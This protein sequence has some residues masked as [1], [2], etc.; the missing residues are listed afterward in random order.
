MQVRANK[1]ACF[2]PERR[3]GHAAALVDGLLASGASGHDMLAGSLIEAVAALVAEPEC[4]TTPEPILTYASLP[5]IACHCCLDLLLSC[6][7]SFWA[8]RTIVHCVGLPV[9]D[10][11]IHNRGGGDCGGARVLHDAGAHFDVREC[12]IACGCRLGV[13][14]CFALASAMLSDLR[15]CLA[16]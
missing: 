7:A 12:N 11:C 2:E 3:S 8:C 13:W 1:D 5:L 14:C 6:F 9:T 4:R 15:C 16:H 10:R